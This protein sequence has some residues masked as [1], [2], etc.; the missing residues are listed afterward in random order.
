MCQGSRVQLSHAPS[1]GDIGGSCRDFSGTAIVLP[2]L[3]KDS[4]NSR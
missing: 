1:F 3:D 2:K 4:P